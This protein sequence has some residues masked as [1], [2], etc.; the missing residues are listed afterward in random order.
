MNPNEFVG[1]PNS[2]SKSLQFSARNPQGLQIESVTLAQQGNVMEDMLKKLKESMKKEK[3]ERGHPGILQWKAGQ[4]GSINSCAPIP[5]P[6]KPQKLSAGKVKIRVLKDEPLTAPPHLPLCESCCCPQPPRQNKMKGPN[7]GQGD[8][9][10]DRQMF[11]GDC[12]QDR[13]AAMTKKEQNVQKSFQDSLLGGD[14]DEEESARSFQEALKQWRQERS[15][16]PEEQAT[17][18]TQTASKS[19]VATQTGFPPE[20][21]HERQGT[22]WGNGKVPIKVEF[23]ESR[24][25]Y[26]DR[27]LLKKHRSTPLEACHPPWVCST[28]LESMNDTL[29]EAKQASSRRGQ[30]EDFRGYCALL[31]AVPVSEIGFGPLNATLDVLDDKQSTKLC[32]LQTDRDQ[33]IAEQSPHKGNIPFVKPAS[34]KER[35]LVPQT[36]LTSIECTGAQLSRQSETPVRP[37]V[38]QGTHPLKPETEREGHSIKMLSTKSKPSYFAAEKANT[39]TSSSKPQMSTSS[40]T[41]HKS[42]HHR[43]SPHSPLFPHHQTELP[44]PF[45]DPSPLIPHEHIFPF[46]PS[47]SLNSAFTVSPSSSASL[48]NAGR[49]KPLQKGSISPVLPKKLQSSQLLLEP[50]PSAMPSQSPTSNLK[51]LNQSHQESLLSDHSLH[52]PSSPISSSTNPLQGGLKLLFSSSPGVSPLPIYKCGSSSLTYADAT[53]FLSSTPTTSVKSLPSYLLKG[54]QDPLK[55]VEMEEEDTP[56]DS[57]SDMSIDSLDLTA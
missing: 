11:A 36:L 47:S 27:L 42:K 51:S 52:F 9:A 7:F 38:L 28:A 4:Y 31:F 20:R 46:P 21:D 44:D 30:D 2:K 25:T 13:R 35:E 55:A 48:L 50:I 45:P 5:N 14:Y 17:M 56:T 43:G 23:H 34:S 49:S 41:I 26:M 39:S 24:L 29:I 16:G 6:K 54:T 8:T 3:G 1:H 22:G 10:T 33:V 19:G 53:G 18:W 15:V 57:E 12:G 40:P 37:K 32:L